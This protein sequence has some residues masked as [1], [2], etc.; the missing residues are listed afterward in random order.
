MIRGSLAVDSGMPKEEWDKKTL[1]VGGPPGTFSEEGS[2]ILE[3][4]LKSFL[5]CVSY[6]KN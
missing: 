3:K 5:E 6:F 2:E 4:I 1:A